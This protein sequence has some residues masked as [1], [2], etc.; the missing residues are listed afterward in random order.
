MLQMRPMQRHNAGEWKGTRASFRGMALCNPLLWANPRRGI[1]EC[2]IK[3]L[4]ND[5]ECNARGH[6]PTS[7]RGVS[8][9]P[10]AP[11]GTTRSTGGGGGDQHSTLGQPP[12]E[13]GRLPE[14][15]TGQVEGISALTQEQGTEC[16]RRLKPI[17]R[18]WSRGHKVLR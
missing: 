17:P 18:P 10:H 8:D 13:G 9:N 16:P 7:D 15:Q 5:H 1:D 2:E 14:P 12:A 4:A 11:T 6:L 3:A